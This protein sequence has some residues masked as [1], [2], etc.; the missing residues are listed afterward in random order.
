MIIMNN[1]NVCKLP[2]VFAIKKIILLDLQLSYV[3]APMR[4]K[5]NIIN[6]I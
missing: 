5:T 4:P 1:N 3:G 2:V 6:K